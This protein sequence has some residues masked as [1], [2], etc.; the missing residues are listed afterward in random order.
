[1][2]DAAAA[3][4]RRALAVEVR[5]DRGA[6]AALRLGR[7]EMS[8]GR[9]AEAFKLL[10]E[11]ANR[12]QTKELAGVRMHAYAA[13]AANEDARGFEKSALGYYILVTELFDDIETVPPA[14]RRVAE[15][16]RKQGKTKEADEV[17]ADLKRRYER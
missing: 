15:I 5:T 4:Y 14:M 11:A 12:A 17:L 2:G 9:H 3:A 8:M 7:Y 10:T 16:L 13:L 1:M 6:Q